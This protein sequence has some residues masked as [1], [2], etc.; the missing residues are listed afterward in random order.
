MTDCVICI[1]SPFAGHAG[2]ILLFSGAAPTVGPGRVVESSLA[3][4]LRGHKDIVRGRAPL[5]EPA[6]NFYGDLST[7]CAGNCHVFDI[8]ACSLDQLGISEQ[9]IMCDNT[10]GCLVLSDTFTTRV[11]E[12][13]F[14]GLFYNKWV[15]FTEQEKDEYPD[16]PDQGREELAMSFN[17]EIRVRC[18][19]HVKWLDG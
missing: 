1:V 6:K 10:G 11:F 16:D 13:S 3:K 4:H 5:H 2:R 18:S 15:P 17:G 8:F 19:R 9:R 14:A 7:R 12:D